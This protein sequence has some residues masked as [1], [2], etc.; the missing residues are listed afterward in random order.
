MI[1]VPFWL[2]VWRQDIR[3]GLR[4]LRRSP[5]FTAVTI[6]ALSIGVGA[7]ITIFSLVNGWL[8]RP[9]DAVNPEQLVRITGPGG[10]SAGV[11]SLDNDAHISNGDYLQYRDL[12]QTFSALAASHVGGPTGVRWD[13][14][15][16]MI[17]VTPVTGNYFAM[18]GVQAALGRIRT[19]DDA[20]SGAR[21]VAVLSDV[22][23][24]RYFH[25][26]S[27]I[28]GTTIVVDGIPHV[29]VGVLPA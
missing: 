22:G 9:L 14:P 17:P 1:N 12:N 5:V 20:R 10:D 16:Q 23:W 24:H 15:A 6:T 27:D 21:E 2:D 19:P 3:Y 8:I 26:A 29:I 11:L 25:G 18:L 4:Q 7:N 13:G 28:V